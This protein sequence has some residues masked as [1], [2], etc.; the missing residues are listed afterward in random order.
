MKCIEGEIQDSQP[1]WN[2]S[3]DD[4]SYPNGMLTLKKPS[5]VKD[6]TIRFPCAYLPGKN[7]VKA[8]HN[9]E[10]QGFGEEES[11]LEANRLATFGCIAT[12]L[13]KERVISKLMRCNITFRELR[14][15]N[16]KMASFI[17]K[18]HLDQ[19]VVWDK[20]ILHRSR[21]QINRGVL[22]GLLSSSNR[23]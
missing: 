12:Q 13:K 15:K 20:R 7:I 23:V 16:Q 6:T 21:D 4:S 14:V 1:L 17:M 22:G 9:T 3:D 2:S 11:R 19:E 18:T 5:R 8:Q 10:C